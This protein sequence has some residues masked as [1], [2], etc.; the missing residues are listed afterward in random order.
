[1]VPSTP[2]SDTKH[3]EST[4]TPQQQHSDCTVT[5]QS[6]HS[7]FCV[8]RLGPLNCEVAGGPLAVEQLQSLLGEGADDQLNDRPEP[9]VLPS[10]STSLLSFLSSLSF[11]FLFLL[12]NS[13]F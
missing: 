10:L 9:G 5:A 1:M 11:S 3:S 4:V 8:R 13:S 7:D 6:Q 12:G 2:H